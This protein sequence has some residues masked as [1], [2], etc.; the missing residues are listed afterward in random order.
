MGGTMTDVLQQGTSFNVTLSMQNRG[1]AVIHRAWTTQIILKNSGGTT[2]FTGTHTFQVKG[3]LP[4]AAANYSTNFTL[5]GASPGTGY[6]LYIK[7]ID[8]L[9]Y[10]QPFYLGNTGRDVTNGDYLLRP[11]IT[12][13]A[14]P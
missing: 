1:N 6:N 12:V 2:V 11:N 5:S 7:L 14:G 8:P 3:F 10:A 9:N 13:V 4:A